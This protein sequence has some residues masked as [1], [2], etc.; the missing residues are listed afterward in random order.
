MGRNLG[1]TDRL[2]IPS[3]EGLAASEQSIPWLVP[4]A[5]RSC[6]IRRRVR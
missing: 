1:N 6:C 3:T 2:R 4:P 5:V